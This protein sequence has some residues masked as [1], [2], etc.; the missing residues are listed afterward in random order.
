MKKDGGAGRGVAALFLWFSGPQPWGWG[1]RGQA[2]V[3]LDGAAPGTGV[4]NRL[5]PILGQDC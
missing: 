3:C 5:F 2:R 1:R 4:E